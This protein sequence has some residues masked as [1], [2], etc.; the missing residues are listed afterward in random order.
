MYRHSKRS[1]CL[2]NFKKLS[3]VLTHRRSFTSSPSPL[4]A[5]VSNTQ[6][7]TDRTLT[8]AHLIDTAQILSPQWK[9]LS[10]CLGAALESSPF[11]GNLLRIGK[12]LSQL[13]RKAPTTAMPTILAPSAKLA[14]Q[15]LFQADRHQPVR[16]TRTRSMAAAHLTP[17]R[18][19][20]LVAMT[21]Y[22]TGRSSGENNIN[23]RVASHEQMTAVLQVDQLLRAEGIRSNHVHDE[24]TGISLQ[25]WKDLL[26]T[27]TSDSIAGTRETGCGS[28]RR[29]VVPCDSPDG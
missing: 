21:A 11:C 3:F 20:V 18:I 26:V 27:V 29:P 10:P 24:W 28:F 22:T 14:T 16:M 17:Q 15:L 5:E 1:F 19:G 9:H 8:H 2:W 13:P 25:R 12:L 4:L 7:S 23:T 6:N